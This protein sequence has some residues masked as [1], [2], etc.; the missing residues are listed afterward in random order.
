MGITF[1]VLV[2]R[3]GALVGRFLGVFLV[4]VVLVAGSF[5]V[6]RLDL[7][8][9]CKGGRELHVSDLGGLVLCG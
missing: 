3:V 9:S 1:L 5:V 6:D 7:E 4:S 8:I 2:G